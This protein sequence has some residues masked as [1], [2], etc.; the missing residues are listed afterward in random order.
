M[1]GINDSSPPASHTFLRSMQLTS[2]VAA[3]TAPTPYTP[4][5]S[6]TSP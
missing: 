6:P 2:D 3:V 5:Q 4:I 1:S